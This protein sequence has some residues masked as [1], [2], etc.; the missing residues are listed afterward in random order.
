MD[1]GKSSLQCIEMGLGEET[2]NTSVSALVL[3]RWTAGNTK[4]FSL[5]VVTTFHG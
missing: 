4:K 2:S 1:N 3:G 5:S